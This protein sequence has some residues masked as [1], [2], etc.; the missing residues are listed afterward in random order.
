MGC[1]RFLLWGWQT[2]NV[3]EEAEEEEG[4]EGDTVGGGSTHTASKPKSRIVGFVLGSIT[5]KRK[6]DQSCGYLCW[7]AVRASYRRRGIGT[8]LVKKMMHLFWE[9]GI[10][11][12]IN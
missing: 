7:V 9:E 12:V 3:V 1:Y 5:E 6:K 10:R 11:Q 8:I 4:D 2:G